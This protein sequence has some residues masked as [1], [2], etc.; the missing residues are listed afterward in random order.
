LGLINT[1]RYH[2]KGQ[3]SEKEMKELLSIGEVK[4]VQTCA[5]PDKHTLQLLNDEYFSKYPHTEFRIYSGGYSVADLT[6]LSCMDNIRKLTINCI[7]DVTNLD[8]IT[9][10]INLKS[11]DIHIENLQ[12][13]SFADKLPE[14]LKALSITSIGNR[15]DVKQLTRLQNLERLQLIKCKKNTD[16]VAE[17]S[18]L[19]Y[20]QL[21][22]FVPKSYD[23][24]NQLQN[25]KILNL[26]NGNVG[27]LSEL[28]GNISI[29]ALSLFHL[30]KLLTL[31]V[32]PNLPKL[33]A[34]W[35][36]QLTNVKT[37]PDLSKSS[38][39]YIY[40]ENMKHLNDFSGAEFAENLKS[41]HCLT[42]PPLIVP[43]DALPVL[44]NKI[45]EQ[46]CFLP[47]SDRKRIQ[48]DE[49]IKQYGKINQM[50]HSEFEYKVSLD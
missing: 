46:M 9:S 41:F 8:A 6:P 20:L 19:R 33:K 34:L 23:F 18:N 15:L 11:L 43:E 24:I 36:C 32:I 49:L 21:L 13:F 3:I 1:S 2:F 30:P 12:D 35:A 5:Q 40:F 48:M 17:L 31:D 14:G 25:L 37:L 28:Y 26:W 22:G 50:T 16:A 39:E 38:V 45:V 29:E 42:C 47:S 10:L 4:V 27:D 7:R 44:R